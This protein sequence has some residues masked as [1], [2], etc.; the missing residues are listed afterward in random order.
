VTLTARSSL[1]HVVEAVASALDKAGIRAVLVGGA[2]A[3][4]YSDG[5]YM[6]EDLDLIIQSAA[7]QRQLDDAMAGIGFT[8]RAAQ[9]FHDK[10]DFFVEFPR[11]PLT[12]GHDVRIEPIVLKIGRGRVLAISATDSCR[13]RLAAFYHWGDRQSLDVAVK[14]ALSNRVRMTLI[15]RWSAGENAS[16]KFEEFEKEL[17]R[18]RRRRRRS[19]GSKARVRRKG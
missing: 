17:D 12:I 15:R 10:T 9:Y 16:A 14:I 3:A 11:G 18:A 8:R 1:E 2:C 4:I 5:V 6:S 19:R 13:D 7:T